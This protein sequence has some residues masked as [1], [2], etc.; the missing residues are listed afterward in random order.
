MLTAICLHSQV[1]LR[2][3]VLN[4]TMSITVEITFYGHF[5]PGNITENIA[6]YNPDMTLK[7]LKITEWLWCYWPLNDKQRRVANNENWRVAI[8]ACFEMI[9]SA[10][11]WLCP[12]KNYSVRIWFKEPPATTLMHV[13][14]CQCTI[15]SQGAAKTACD[16]NMRWNMFL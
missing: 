4:C 9:K 12:K 1:C 11:V 6:L 15:K 13:R 2:L 10:I 14:I 8:I 16:I 3:E 7:K 5:P